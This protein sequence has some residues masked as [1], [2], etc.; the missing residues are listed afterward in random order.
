MRGSAVALA[1]GSVYGGSAF[2]AGVPAAVSPPVVVTATRVDDSVARSIVGAQVITANDI[3]MSRASTLSELLRWS[4]QVRTRDLPGSPNALIDLRGFGAVGDQN[5]LVLVDGMRV[6]EY[7]QLS[8]NWASIPL[9]SIERIEILPAASGVLYGGGSTGGVVNIVTRA[10]QGGAPAFDLGAEVGSHA[11]REARMSV[12]IAGGAV[13]LRVHGSRYETDNYRDNQRVRV[14]NAGADVRWSGATGSLGVRFGADD[15]RHGL[16]GVISE[17]QM[18]VN[19]RQAGMPR[20]FTTIDGGYVNLVAQTPVRSADL[21]VNLG[22]RERDTSAS[23]L[24]AT[25]FRNSVDTQVNVWSV[26]PRLTFEPRSGWL[27]DSFIVGADF[28][29]WRFASV[30]Q[31]SIVS[32]PHSTQRSG[33]L[34]V[35]HAVRFSP[36]GTTLTWG[37]RGQQVRSEVVDRS[38]AASAGSRRHTLRAW[39]VSL[40]HALAPRIEVYGKTGSSFRVPNVNDNFNPFMA[41]VTLLDPQT[42]R[43]AE[44]GIE[45]GSA[46]ARYRATLHRSSLSNEIFFDPLTLGSRNR[47]PTRRQG[48]ALE[49]RWQLAPP[50]AI[51]ASY[52]YADAAFR[53]GT[54]SGVSI[55]GHRVPL[56]PRHTLR[57]GVHWAFVAAARVDL[58]IRRIGSSVFDLDEIN[59]FGRE[60][61]AYT[62]A[63]LKVSLRQGGWLLK[64][65][66]RNLLSERYF[67]YGVVTGRPTYSG[68]PEPERSV[69][70]SAQHALP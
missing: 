67:S 21:T 70:V 17:A 33:A 37:A 56:V 45:G 28:E 50:L 54:V 63:D 6:R 48:L 49:G 15:Q 14:D 47:P 36:L 24:V 26:S 16:P 4:S 31:P 12:G 35:Q 2:P 7:E 18:A 1:F 32:A 19:P 40:R 68:I 25:P 66:V 53:K 59:A 5:T 22:Y 34:Y 62:V 44:L 39:D 58:D 61:P 27:D 30:S 29:R 11:A 65:G 52:V 42:A 3:A 38:R 43:D 23:F 57:A 46:H 41:R 10:P 60:I 20:D 13:G 9:P 51:E 8:V 64:A 69:F 55:A